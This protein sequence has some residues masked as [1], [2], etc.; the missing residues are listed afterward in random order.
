[1]TSSISRRD[2]LKLSGVGLGA[3]T[4]NTAFA[5][6]ARL[7]MPPP[8]FPDAPRLGRI[9]GKT[10]VRSAPSW[11]AP[12]TETLYDDAV[13][14]WL[15]ETAAK[16]LDFNQINQRWVEI[17]QGYV[18]AHYIQPVRNEPNTPLTAMPEGQAGFWAEVTV[19]YVDFSIAN[20]PARSFFLR[21]LIE[22]KLPTRFYYSQVLWVDQIQPADD[23]RI[24]Y[25]L[26]ERYG[27]PG[28]IFW[29]DARAFRPITE[30]DLAPISPDVDPND[31]RIVV[32]LTY[33]TL[34]CYEGK[35]E[36]YFCRT[37]TGVADKST[38]V[39]TLHTWRKLVSVRMA[40]G[41]GASGWD[42]PGVSWTTLVK[43]DGVAIHSTF[44][45]NNYGQKRSHGCIN[46]TPEDARWVFRWTT[47]YA[48]LDT[49]DITVQWPNHG[50]IVQV[51]ERLF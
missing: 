39:G 50:T 4:L 43:G 8:Q 28:D 17:P 26:T 22:K 49:G 30:A 23:G 33:Q 41:T 7:L 31:K 40:S 42:T 48:P 10:E 46:V 6:A 24:L 13:V 11:D 20:P 15:R 47:P 35:Q 2:F 34:T 12:I 14:P 5:P 27:N 18:F 16:T 37:S 19:P 25:R 29:A 45:H 32:N 51:E 36:V 1:M 21:N 44:W 3:L 9:F 38:P